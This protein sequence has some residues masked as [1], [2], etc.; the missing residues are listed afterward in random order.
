[1]NKIKKTLV[2]SLALIMGASQ[3]VAALPPQE[4][5]RY[6]TQAAANAST[7]QWAAEQCPNNT[8][9]A[10]AWIGSSTFTAVVLAFTMTCCCLCCCCPDDDED[11]KMDKR[12]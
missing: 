5:A 4:F 7:M 6:I 2:F 8:Q 12:W 1:M 9:G 11:Q 10:L 3:S